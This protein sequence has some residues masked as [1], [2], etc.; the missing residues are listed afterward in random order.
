LKKQ[1]HS[2]VKLLARQPKELASISFEGIN[3]LVNRATAAIKIA[4]DYSA[5]FTIFLEATI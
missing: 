1:Y 5:Y 4:F 3:F 2:L